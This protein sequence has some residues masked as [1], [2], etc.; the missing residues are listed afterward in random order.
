MG[1]LCDQPLFVI[2]P[3]GE[4]D[5]AWQ[6]TQTIRQSGDSQG[7]GDNYYWLRGIKLRSKP[8]VLRHLGLAADQA[9]SAP[10]GPEVFMDLDDPAF[11]QP[12]GRR[13]RKCKS[14]FPAGH[15]DHT[16]ES[17]DLD[18]INGQ[19]SFLQPHPKRRR[20][21]GGTRSATFLSLPL[22]LFPVS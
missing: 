1:M 13:T 7:G 12:N 8:E 10:E 19:S 14:G 22:P 16:Q 11:L 3:G 5:E 2:L 15:L 18:L 6:V 17:S 4:W 20:T 9:K 21:G